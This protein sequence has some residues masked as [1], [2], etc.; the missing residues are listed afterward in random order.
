MIYSQRVALPFKK[1]VVKKPH[2][3]CCSSSWVKQ[4]AA[5]Y[6][7]HLIHLKKIYLLGRVWQPAT[8]YNN[9]RFM[10]LKKS[11]KPPLQSA[12]GCHT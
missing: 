10:L 6:N 2:G 1:S 9:G 12:A 4:P 7:G 5:D 11:V 3:L 8:D